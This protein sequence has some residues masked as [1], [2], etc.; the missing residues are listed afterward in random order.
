MSCPV[1]LG[2]IRVN[3]EL[4]Y[5]FMCGAMAN[6]YKAQVVN[7]IERLI[8]D[9]HIFMAGGGRDPGTAWRR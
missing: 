7:K 5:P 2:G 9:R 6:E 1:S 8:T 3:N 4:R